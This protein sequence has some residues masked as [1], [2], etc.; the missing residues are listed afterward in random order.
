MKNG[1]IAETK[2][3]KL[4]TRYSNCVW[5]MGPDLKEKDRATLE[6]IRKSLWDEIVQIIDSKEA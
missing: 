4:M 3:E 5:L 6:D 1:Y 2:G